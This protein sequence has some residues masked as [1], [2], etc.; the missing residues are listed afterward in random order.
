M[1]IN[2]W[3]TARILHTSAGNQASIC[4]NSHH[5][6]HSGAA[7]HYAKYLNLLAYMVL[8]RRIELRTSPLP[9]E[10]CAAINEPEMPRK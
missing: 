7:M 4:A 3:G 8:Q 5:S 10:V 2:G 1:R 9:R 6:A